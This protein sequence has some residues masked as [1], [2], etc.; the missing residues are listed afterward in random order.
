[1]QTVTEAE[2]LDVEERWICEILFKNW[3]HQRRFISLSLSLTHT[4]IMHNHESVQ[5]FQSEK[6][7]NCLKR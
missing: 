3:I 4:R 6:K 5:D 1:M 2:K 7:S